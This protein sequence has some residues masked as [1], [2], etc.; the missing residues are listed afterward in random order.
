MASSSWRLELAMYAIVLDH[1]LGDRTIPSIPIGSLLTAAP[2]PL[3]ATARLR[4]AHILRDLSSSDSVSRAALT[5]LTYL[6]STP[7]APTVAAAARA[8]LTVATYLAVH[9]VN[10][11]VVIPDLFGAKGAP[12][13][14]RRGGRPVS[15]G[16]GDT[17]RAGHPQGPVGR[18]IGRGT[19][20]E[21]AHRGRVG[22]D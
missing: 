13:E 4:H 11:D 19:P 14:G 17:H 5:Y 8:H 2:S 18:S 9:A 22:R 7:F 16:H 1:L 3:H 10:F 12:P 15:R 21:G 6:A 20:G